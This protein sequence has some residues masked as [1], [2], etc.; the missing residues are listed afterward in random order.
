MSLALFLMVIGSGAFA[1]DTPIDPSM[2]VT[3]EIIG[4]GDDGYFIPGTAQLQVKV[5][6]NYTG[7][8]TVSGLGYYEQ[9]PENWTYAGPLATDD[10]PPNPPVV[11]N[12]NATGLLNFAY[13]YTPR[14]PAS[15]TYTLNTANFCEPVT[16]TGYPEFRTTGG[17]LYGPETV[18]TIS[19]VPTSV[20]FTREL[21]GP[22]VTGSENNF[23]VPGETIDVTI[24]FNKEG[25]DSLTAMGFQDT[26]PEGWTYVSPLA[27]DDPPP[28]PPV[29]PNE[30]ASGLLE[31]AYIYVP[32]FP[33][34]FTYTIR[35]ADDAEGPAA[36]GDV[37]TTADGDKSSAV[38]YR[39]CGETI[40][41]PSVVNEFG[42][43]APCIAV[44]RTFA[45]GYYQPGETLDVTITFGFVGDPCVGLSA[46][47]YKET[48]PEGWT[49]VGPLSDD[50]PPPVPPVVPNL[51]ATGTLE[52]A[53]IYVPNIANHPHFTYTIR[54]SEASDGVQEFRGY[55]E[56]RTTGDSIQSDFAVSTIDNADLVPPEIT[57]IGD[58][59]VDVECHTEYVDA[60]ATAS[61]NVDGDISGN[62]QTTNTVDVNVV[63]AYSVT[64]N[65]SDLAGNAATPVVRTVNVVDTTAPEI[66]L[67]GSGTATVQC[68][69]GYVDAGATASDTCAGALVPI[70]S[71]SVNT[72][73]PGDYT[74][75]YNVQDPAGNAAVSVS[76]VVTVVDTTAPVISLIGQSSVT[77]ECH[78]AYT[79]NGATASDTCDGAL[80][81]QPTSNVNVDDPGVYTVTY[82]VSDSAGNA[83]VPVT[84]TVTVQDTTL[85]QI[86]LNGAST[87]TVE[88]H[89]GAYNELGATATDTCDGSLTT[90]IEI[91]GSVDVNTPN[92]YTINYR[93]TDDAGNGATTA[94][95]VIVL[96]SVAPVITLVGSA[97]ITVECGGSYTD[98]GATV[99][100][101]CDASVTVQTVNP[102]NTLVPGVYTVTYNASDAEGNQAA[103][104][105]RTVT[106]VD[107]TSP[108]LTLLGDAAVTVECGGS[109][110]DA[111]ASAS[112]TCDDDEQLTQAIVVTGGPVDTS[113]PGTYTLTYSVS[114][115][116]G[117][118]AAQVSR[119]VTVQDTMKPVISLLGDAA[120][121]V[122]CGNAYVDNGATVA[123]E[124]DA[125]VQV[126]VDGQVP[127]TTGVYT[128][129]YNAT[130]AAGN[131]AD[132][133]T[134]TVTVA[135]TIAPALALIGDASVEVDCGSTYQDAGVTANDACDG[136]LAQS[137]VVTGGP[138]DTAQ[139]ASFTLTYNVSDAAGNAAPQVSRTV[140]VTGPG[141]GQLPC[142]LASVAITAP[143]DG[144][145]IVIPQGAN[146]AVT[147]TSAIAFE[148]NCIEGDV[149]VR[150]FINDEMKGTSSDRAAGFPLVVNL[151]EG[152]YTLRADAIVLETSNTVSDTVAFTVFGLESNYGLPNDPFTNL[153]N[154][155]DRWD[156]TATLPGAT[157][158]RAITMLTWFGSCGAGNVQPVTLTLA[159]AEDAN[160]TVTVTI[161][162][163]LLTCQ[164][165][166]IV[167]I[168]IS[169]DLAGLLGVDQAG[170]LGALPDDQSQVQGGAPFEISILVQ[171][172]GGNIVE[173]DNAIIAQNPIGITLNGMNFMADYIASFVSH[174]TQVTGGVGATPL[175]LLAET[176]DWTGGAISGAQTSGTSL[177]ALTSSLSVFVPVEQPAIGPTLSVTPS[178]AYDVVFG[179][180]EI[181]KKITKEFTVKNIGGG[182]LVGT[183]TMAAA[184]DFK[185]V[186]G[187]NYSLT[188]GQSAKVTVEFAPTKTGNLTAALTFTGQGGQSQVATLKG[189]GTVFAKR[190][191]FFGCAPSPADGSTLFGDIVVALA[192][193][194][195][196]ML[197][198]RVYRRRQN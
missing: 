127:D 96:D 132:E 184:S 14:F 84:R 45:Q 159:Q 162:R 109:Y 190:F 2:T 43:T 154:D 116:A 156:A 188:M 52:F 122:E 4:L 108:S 129:S 186:S 30:G 112:D 71:G 51:D 115:A 171:D 17:A 73:S 81:P 166:G 68:G 152:E 160:Q 149:E 124:C 65:V 56:Y 195:G 38:S 59:T 146:T 145:R 11:P 134:R 181:G 9:L 91:T 170:L 194:G 26:I 62:I 192:L 78:S 161:P 79:D 118:A 95:T 18:T 83:A 196:L 174:G 5:T 48:V 3:K 47:G 147:L 40:N 164:Q 169:C 75:T 42:G 179:I 44:T 142:D 8:D 58:A 12:E 53:Y 69:S 80:T 7:T 151:T 94:R 6:F 39:T 41:S 87:V 98:D 88:C 104:V 136:D 57:L 114:D 76:R 119:T 137:V 19:R 23:Y 82:N 197:A 54:A 175:Q 99:A 77:V 135:D 64:Y 55:A 185:V 74:I 103:Q 150:Y 33:A 110:T 105:T 63:G 46:L 72:S 140:V 22:G 15:F 189:T 183:A 143:T 111:G 61:D 89:T 92:S 25:T 101:A 35:V 153:P 1:A 117:N 67:I 138:I 168:G 130:D 20:T 60:G 31:F 107:T 16:L 86:A 90:D 163:N 148:E 126:V 155:G 182:T 106:V 123:D 102:V 100:D 191:T 120:V 34:S 70:P 93:V 85:P 10:P 133:V 13:I 177:S 157:C 158:P 141:C 32:R 167:I 165:R 21:S 187:A 128:I 24:T 178:T 131:V 125:A 29:V 139:P 37:V 36:I 113:A 97:E 121:T 27:T 28:V 193:F 198:S 173:L 49:Y 172:N 176:G 144:S 180:S 66:A 50:D